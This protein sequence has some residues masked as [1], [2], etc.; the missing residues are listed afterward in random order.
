MYGSSLPVDSK[1][2]RKS[3]KATSEAVEGEASEPNPKKAKKEKVVQQVKQVGPDMPTIQDEVQDLEPAKILNKRT[4]GGTSTGSSGAIPPQPKIQKKKK[5]VSKMI[6]QE[7][8]AEIEVATNLVTREVRKKKVV[9]AAALHQAREIAKD[10]EVPDKC[11][12]VTY[13]MC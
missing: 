12:K 4:R 10:I 9:D 2:K 13:F 5:Q 3:K 7:E 11:S 8:D 6:H 1:K